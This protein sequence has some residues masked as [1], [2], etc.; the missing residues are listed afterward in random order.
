MKQQQELLHPEVSI[1]RYHAIE[2]SDM[3]SRLFLPFSVDNP[4]SFLLNL[5]PTKSINLRT[6]LLLGITVG[7]QLAPSNKKLITLSMI[8]PLLLY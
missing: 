7:Q 4:I 8:K 5:L 3:H 6:K 2:C 1:I